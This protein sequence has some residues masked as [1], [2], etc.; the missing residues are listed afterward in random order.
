MGLR[1]VHTL[2]G[3]WDQRERRSTAV[4]LSTRHRSPYLEHT[5][6][7]EWK[8][9]ITLMSFTGAKH[10][11]QHCAYALYWHSCHVHPILEEGANLKW[12]WVCTQQ[13]IMSRGHTHLLRSVPVYLTETQVNPIQLQSREMDIIL[14]K[15]LLSFKMFVHSVWQCAYTI[16]TVE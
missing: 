14:Q 12:D 8:Q 10:L 4:P 7:L 13:S 9:S 11:A 2:G 3:G 15:G 5:K 6:C 16:L 1:N